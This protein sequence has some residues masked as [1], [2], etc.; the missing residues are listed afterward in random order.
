M[1][2]GKQEKKKERERDLSLNTYNPVVFDVIVDV[3]LIITITVKSL[4]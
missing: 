3:R 2:R 4:F 1:K